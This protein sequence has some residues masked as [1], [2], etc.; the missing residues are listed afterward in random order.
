MNQLANTMGGKIIGMVK[1]V[2]G[3]HHIVIAEFADK[4]NKFTVWNY[5]PEFHGFYQGYYTDSYKNAVTE[6]KRRLR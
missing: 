3:D 5:N 6:M 1:E 4:F 2:D